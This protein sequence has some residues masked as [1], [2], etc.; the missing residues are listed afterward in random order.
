LRT[1]NPRVRILSCGVAMKQVGVIGSGNVGA[2][3]AFFIAENRAASVLLVDVKQG[4]S[5]GKA[6]DISEA[7]PIRHYDTA[8][9]GSDDIGAIRDSDV[10]VIAAGRVR[11][12]GESREDLYRDNGQL[13]PRIC[14]DI[15]ELSPGA[16]VINVVEPVDMTTLLAQRL[17]GFDRMRV[18]GVGG[19]LSSTRLRYLVSTALGVSPRDVT[20]MVIGPHDSDMVI[21]RDSVRIS[22]IPADKLLSGEQFDSIIGQVRKADD[23]ILYM[24]QQ[25]AAFYAPSAAIAALV[26]AVVRDTRAI[27]PVS[28]RLAGEYGQSDVAVSVPAQIG[29]RGIDRIVTVA[30]SAA[31]RAGFQNAIASL[32]S[33]L[34]RAGGWFDRTGGARDA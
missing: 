30:L 15:R 11:R 18:L 5:A 33:S 16:V 6:L 1:L 32:R 23:T 34:E 19:L 28:V 17:L 31:E 2:N 12:P 9:R 14:A 7:G 3:C 27:L 13:L 26:D 29:S 10:V 8:I 25:A 22:G 24:S 21:P 20:G 4:L